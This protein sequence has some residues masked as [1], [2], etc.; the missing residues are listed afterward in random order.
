MEPRRIVDDEILV[1]SLLRCYRVKKQAIQD[2]YHNKTFYMQIIKIYNWK[3]QIRQQ[4]VVDQHEQKRKHVEVCVNHTKMTLPFSLS[5]LPESAVA[6]VDIMRR[7]LW[8]MIVRKEVL[9]AQ[10]RKMSFKEHKI[11]KSK[12]LAHRCIGHLKEFKRR[13]SNKQISEQTKTKICNL[14]RFDLNH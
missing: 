9:H 8:L 2:V 7:N 10:R 3:Q 11:V 4:L 1:K 12:S 6:D 13:N 5:I 14:K